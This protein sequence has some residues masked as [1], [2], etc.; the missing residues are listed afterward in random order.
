MVSFVR[1]A[2]KLF[3]LEKIKK[4][5]DQMYEE[6]IMSSFIGKFDSATEIAIEYLINGK[7]RM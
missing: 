4:A 5:Y 2:P 3:S 1:F 7:L 6:S